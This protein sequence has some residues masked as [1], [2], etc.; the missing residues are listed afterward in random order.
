[1]SAYLQSAH[2]VPK[3][4]LRR[5]PTLRQASGLL[6]LLLQTQDAPSELIV[7][8]LRLPKCCFHCC[9]TLPQHHGLCL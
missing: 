6:Q 4:S 9:P 8:L 2:L 5:F 3:S 7:F 1:M